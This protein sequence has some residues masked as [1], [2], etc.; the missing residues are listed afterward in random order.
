[1]HMHMHMHRLQNYVTFS[2]GVSR[3]FSIQD[4][5]GSLASRDACMCMLHM[6]MHM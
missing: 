3:G 6:C 5:R 2:F 4:V 1:M